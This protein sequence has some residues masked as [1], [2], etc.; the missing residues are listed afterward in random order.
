[1]TLAH[2]PPASQRL[3]REGE[4]P[5]LNIK[6]DP[7]GRSTRVDWR[8]LERSHGADSHAR[9]GGLLEQK[10]FFLRSQIQEAALLALLPSF[11]FFFAARLGCPL[12]P[13]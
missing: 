8:A 1:M 9:A 13:G 5:C 6:I 10:G 7:T 2:D 4:T 12:M 11:M 3:R